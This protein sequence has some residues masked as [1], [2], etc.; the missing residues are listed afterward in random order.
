MLSHAENSCEITPS[1]RLTRLA[2]LKEWDSGEK[3]PSHKENYTERISN[4]WI[5][6]CIR[7]S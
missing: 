4:T 5:F 1:H 6:K 3:T 7:H 2:G